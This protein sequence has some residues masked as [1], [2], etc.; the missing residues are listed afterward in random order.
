[1]RDSNPRPT[2]CKADA[3]TTAPIAHS[4]RL[5]MP[6]FAAGAKANVASRYGVTPLHWAARGGSVEVVSLLI[7]RGESLAAK[8]DRGDTPLFWAAD[9]GQLD[10]ARFLVEHGADVNAT[11]LF[12]GTP[13]L[14][15][16]RAKES[17]EFV[18]FL[19]NAGADVKARDRQGEIALHK[20]AWFVYPQLNVESAQILLDAGAD[21]AAKNQ[22]GKTPLD[23]LLDNSMKNDDLVKL[24]HEYADKKSSRR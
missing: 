11:N 17:P 2:A 6:E 20:L 23:I 5:K 4:R 13:L 18:K 22:D 9:A 14:T 8:D 19:I 21:I 10:T 7:S 3:L 15:V 12:G 24:F 1:M 16:A